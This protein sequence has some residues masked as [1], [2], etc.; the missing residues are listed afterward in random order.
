MTLQMK[1]DAQIITCQECGKECAQLEFIR[2]LNVCD[3]LALDSIALKT[4]EEQTSI[5]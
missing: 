2:G 3:H 1:P 5:F 4:A